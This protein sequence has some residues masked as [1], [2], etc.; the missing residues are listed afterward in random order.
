MEDVIKKIIK[1]EE[2]AQAIIASTLQ[3]NEVKRNATEERLKALEEQIVGD[4]HKKAKELRKKELSANASYAKEIRSQCD[5]RIK[6]ME[7][8]AKEKS[9]QWVEYLLGKVLGD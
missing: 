1:I 6:A 8:T 7:D 4:A 5:R 9:D 3:E 2:K